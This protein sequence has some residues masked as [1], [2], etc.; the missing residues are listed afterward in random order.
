MT[1]IVILDD[2]QQVALRM[3]D[4]SALQARCEIDV[5]D[6]HIDD[7]ETLAARLAGAEVVLAMRERTPFDAARL[8]LLASGG[9]TVVARP[10]GVDGE[11][12]RWLAR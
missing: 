5:L 7:T 2:Y 1:R 9:T 3:A 6:A 11:E 10:R 8:E 12:M 4:W